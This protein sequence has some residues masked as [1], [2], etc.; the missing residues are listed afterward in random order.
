MA[1]FARRVGEDGPAAYARI[2]RWGELV[3]QESTVLVARLFQ[4]LAVISLDV[5]GEHSPTVGFH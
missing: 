1:D 5:P 2:A 4:H 3:E